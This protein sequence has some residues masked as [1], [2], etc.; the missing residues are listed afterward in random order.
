MPTLSAELEFEIDAALANVSEIDDALGQA[1]ASFGDAL[2]EALSSVSA[3]PI[4]LETGAA[5]DDLDALRSLA[6][7]PVEL[8][9]AADT[10]GADADVAALEAEAETPV[11]KPVSADTA[12]ADAVLADLQAEAETPAEKP[13][14]LDAS[15]ATDSL[16]GL[17]AE[18][19]ETDESLAGVQATT[20]ALSGAAELTTGSV[21]GL[22][23][24]LGGASA[25]AGII[26]TVVSASAGA[27]G[28]FFDKAIGAT[29]A[30][31]RYDQSLGSMADRVSTI[32]VGTLNEDLGELSTKLGSSASQVRNAAADLFTFGE[33]SGAAAPEVAKTTEEVIALSA[34]AVALNPALGTVGDVTERAMT[35][36]ASGRDRALIPFQLGLD[37]NA[38]AARALEIAMAAGRDE[39]TAYDK[40]QATAALGAEKFGTT[41]DQTVTRGAQNPQI[42]LRRLGVEAGAAITKLGAPLIIPMFDALEAGIP[43]GIEAAALLAGLGSVTLPV[44][45]AVFEALT[46]LLETANAL[47]G[48]LPAPVTASAL[49]GGLFYAKWGPIPGVL[50]A[51][52]PLIAALPG[53]LGNAAV[54][55][56]TFAVIGAQ[57][58]KSLPGIGA[59]AGAAAGG[60]FGLGSA[61][62]GAGGLMLQGAAAGALLG[63]VIPVIG[64][65]AGAAIGGVAGLGAGLLGFGEKTVATEERIAKLIDRITELGAVP[66]TLA[67]LEE[68]GTIGTDIDDLNNKL[69][70]LAAESPAA[71]EKVVAGFERMAASSDEG[72]AAVGRHAVQQGHLREV[73]EQGTEAFSR[74]ASEAQSVSE[75]DAA[76]ADSATSASSAISAESAAFDAATAAAAEYVSGLDAI[77]GKNLSAAEAAIAYADSVDKANSALFSSAEATGAVDLA[78]REVQGAL[79]D[80]TQAAVAN[81]EA[82]I[83]QTNDIP[84]ASAALQAH[85]QS[86]LDQLAAYGVVG[87]EA[88]NF[89]NVL[90]ITPLVVDPAT[91]AIQGLGGALAPIPGAAQSAAAGYKA[92]MD[93]IPNATA[94]AMIAA[95][96]AAVVNTAQLVE[97]G[98]AAGDQFFVA[99]GEGFAKVPPDVAA[100]VVAAGGQVISAGAQVTS[101]GQQVGR[102]SGSALT[103]AFEQALKAGAAPAQ[104]GG[105]ALAVQAAQG[106]RNT[107]LMAESGNALQNAFADA[108]RGGTGPASSAGA[109]LASQAAAGTRNT[110]EMAAAGHALG[111]AFVGAVGSH[112]GAARAAG[113]ALGRA[114][115][116]GAANAGSPTTHLFADLGT[117]LG[118]AL[119]S[120]LLATLPRVERVG[121]HMLRDVAETSGQA[122]VPQQL[123]ANLRGTGGLEAALR[124][125]TRE[126]ARSRAG[127]T[128]G[129]GW[130]ELGRLGPGDFRHGS[131]G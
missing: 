86:L 62:G 2:A 96:Q 23:G 20:G 99:T 117:D 12:G 53:D 15:G 31:L 35:A 85:R 106:T 114:A 91:G 123:D 77:L 14:E 38:I 34:R 125:L 33:S 44:L 126:V 40:V 65:G 18:A 25:K 45:I 19:E 22:G 56:A 129:S 89:L 115:A 116:E 13:V 110:G 58:G 7:E 76:I 9:V 130:P 30:T 63:S 108:L 36:F 100:Q 42:E 92:G 127:A 107:G 102:E 49:A 124:D 71:A 66:S 1:A 95:G 97:Q 82:Y 10:G 111:S 39:V 8:P 90:G 93:Q 105:H 48:S 57:L 103:G 59:G 3:A 112:E 54:S 88:E 16:S 6:E 32:N 55:G 119:S 67:F 28:L 37:K 74:H 70:T 120:G 118:E 24:A 84:G 69:R 21:S 94:L 78:N 72:E 43:F 27:L 11:E 41:L 29:S 122:A 83:R 17:G 131:T 75:K 80:S 51:V 50:A 26:G 73:L 4:E 60:V 113:A 109:A 104:A 61:V 5:L 98:R 52:L 128:S 64:T 47:I 87:P 101:S 121:R 79:I 68:F 81:A 46:P